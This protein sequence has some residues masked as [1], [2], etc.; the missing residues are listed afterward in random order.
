MAFTPFTGFGAPAVRGARTLAHTPE[1]DEGFLN[2]LGRSVMSGLAVAGNLLDLPGSMVRDAL[3][4]NNP[5]DQWADPFGG[6]DRVSG[7]D[8]LEQWGVLDENEEGFDAGDVGG[9]A[10]EVLTDPLTFLTGGLT[11]AGKV[12]E[13]GG[14]LGKA[15]KP[16]SLGRRTAQVDSTLGDVIQQGTSQQIQSAARYA[17]KKGFTDPSKYGGNSVLALK[18]IADDTLSTGLGFRAGIPF[19]DIGGGFN[20]GGPIGRGA[21]KLKD[22]AGRA[23]TAVP[24]VKSLKALFSAPLRS[25][26]TRTGQGFMRAASDLVDSGR[27]ATK[28]MGAEA[29]HALKQAQAASGGTFS[30]E[31]LMAWAEG[32]KAAPPEVDSVLAPFRDEFKRL[33]DEAN[34]IGMDIPPIKDSFIDVDNYW[35]RRAQDEI[36]AARR[37][38]GSAW[39]TDDPAQRRRRDIYRNL[40]GG[41]AQVNEGAKAAK[42]AFDAGASTDDV[43]AIL[44]RMHIDD[45]DYMV[46]R[47][48]AWEHGT[49][50]AK[51]MAKRFEDL[52]KEDP[53]VL[54]KGIFRGSIVE[55]ATDA[56]AHLREKVDF[57]RAILDD[58]AKDE[59]W[60]KQATKDFSGGPTMDL[61]ELLRQGRFNVEQAKDYILRQNPGLDLDNL[62]IP[63]KYAEDMLRGIQRFESPAAVGEFVRTFD[64]FTKMFKF[65]VLTWPA[66]Y[67]RD[68]IGGEFRNFQAGI[69]SFNPRTIADAHYMARGQLPKGLTKRYGDLPFVRQALRRKGIQNPTDIDIRDILEERAFADGVV[70][71]NV[72]AAEIAP[73]DHA[74]FPSEDPGGYFKAAKETVGMGPNATLSPKEAGRTFWSRADDPTFQSKF[75]PVV[76]GG[77]MSEV[78]EAGTRMHGWLT[79]I[80][81]G[82]DPEE[83]A[84]KVTAAQ[85]DYT[86]RALTQFQRRVMLRIFPFGRFMMGNIPWV[87]RKLLSPDGARLR[88]TI[89][90]A[91]TARGDALAPEYVQDRLS[92]PF[93][94]APGGEDQWLSAGGA[95]FEP[96]MDDLFGQERLMNAISQMHPLIK[97]PLEWGFG[98][99]TFQRGPRGGRELEDMDPSIG[100]TLA[101]VFGDDEPW[102]WPGSK[103]HEHIAANTP[104]SRAI[105][106][107]R[108]LTD[109]RKTG[110]AKALNAL[111][112]ARVSTISPAAKDAIIREALEQ[113]MKDAGAYGFEKVTFTK[114]DLEKM[115]PETRAAA[116]ELKRLSAILA[117]RAKDR[118]KAKEK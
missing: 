107:T 99:S 115:D 90:A 67:V 95:M 66:R 11:R 8:M 9:F 29:R 88:G 4:G 33:F 55:D 7:R 100:R 38:G 112:G 79:Q 62:A 117:K 113:R 78:S 40:P 32:I 114:A 37:T 44:E 10:A 1:E 3:T 63:Q 15:S 60:L 20:I 118:K 25:A 26:T 30:P 86:N 81:K 64:K 68:K 80:R 59:G 84:R 75:G 76:G 70:N 5:F 71:Q 91:N 106:T 77:R 102:R 2:S 19:T 98:E 52:Y 50:R 92:I 36:K 28:L 49:G 103:L 53:E 104:F 94:D 22:A 43:A 13:A 16:S 69:F 73:P 85:I 42:A 31:D 97:G 57:R 12:A 17:A 116:E 34:D 24:G 41:A 105:T 51:A 18:D 54:G 89:R 111:T 101:N 56:A 72:Y 35:P 109:T 21:A 93:P 74:M 108:A 39:F 48:G 82:I 46:F 6:S 110:L 83:A 47:N 87:A 96:A 65:G 58:F 27:G 45:A 61:D 14:L 23:V